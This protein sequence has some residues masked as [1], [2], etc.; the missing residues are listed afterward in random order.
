MSFSMVA[1][2]VTIVCAA[3]FW[4][5]E[6]CHY[7]NSKNMPKGKLFSQLFQISRGEGRRWV[8]FGLVLCCGT[9]VADNTV[10]SWDLFQAKRGIHLCVI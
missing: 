7:L 5:W 6:E 9:C 8:H 1:W 10:P 4:Y 2:P 3:A